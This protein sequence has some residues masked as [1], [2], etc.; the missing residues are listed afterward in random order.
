MT[1]KV[2]LYTAVFGKKDDIRVPKLDGADFIVFTDD[3]GLK[4]DG[5]D[6]RVFPP[7]DADPC[8]AAKVFK[9]CPDRFLP[10]DCDCSVWVDANKMREGMALPLAEL[11][12]RYLKEKPIAVFR[13]P[14]PACIYQEA[15]LCLRCGNDDPDLIRRQMRAYRAAGFPAGLG[16]AGGG[17]IFR[18]HTPEVSRFGSAWW[19]E[20]QKF[21]RRDQLSFD[22]VAWRLSLWPAVI[23]QQDWAW[24][25]I[26]KHLWERRFVPETKARMP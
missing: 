17:I 13:N 3:P 21:S 18:R 15:E 9:V 11:A 12:E 10:A 2:V 25:P 23:P 5:L 14:P 6:V 22:Y 7:G 8:R 19:E 1:H 4:V 26:R 16:R 24:F 20:I